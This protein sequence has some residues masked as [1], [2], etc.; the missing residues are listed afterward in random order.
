MSQDAAKLADTIFP[1]VG[2][3]A[4]AAKDSLVPKMPDLPVP[5][6]VPGSPDDV[7]GRAARDAAAEEARK[8]SQFGRAST[9]PTGGLG[10]TSTPNLAAKSLLG[11]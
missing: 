9:N 4:G 1:G 6:V 8:R 10:D 7:A 2:S 11:A 3:A 5:P